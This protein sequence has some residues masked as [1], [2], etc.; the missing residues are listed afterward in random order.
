MRFY[1]PPESKNAQS[2]SDAGLPLI[3]RPA[4]YERRVTGYCS[5]ENLT[6]SLSKKKEKISGGQSENFGRVSPGVEM[7]QAL[8]CVYERMSGFSSAVRNEGACL[9]RVQG[10]QSLT[11]VVIFVIFLE[12]YVV[13]SIAVRCPSDGKDGMIPRME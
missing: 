2:E 13:C 1:H 3:Q 6:Y 9:Q 8:G 12:R 5:N 4:S 11:A 10:C 7:N